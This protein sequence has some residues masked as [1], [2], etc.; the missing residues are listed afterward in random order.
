MVRCLMERRD[1]N[2]RVAMRDERSPLEFPQTIAASRLK[3][4][5]RPGTDMPGVR[6]EVNRVCGA[7]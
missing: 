5:S 7:V 3:A 4:R 6:P 1:T 2:K